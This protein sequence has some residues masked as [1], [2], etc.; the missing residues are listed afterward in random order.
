MTF[1]ESFLQRMQFTIICQTFN[2]SDLTSVSLNSQQGTTL[3]G[4]SIYMDGAGAAT[5]GIAA[6]MGAS[7]TKY[8]PQVMHQ[9]YRG[10]TLSVCL[11]PLT[12]TVIL[13]LIEF[14]V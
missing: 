5:A 2:G 7:K 14:R 4:F 1:V 10:S 8:I 13:M 11:T 9:Q 6:Y 12:V 3:C